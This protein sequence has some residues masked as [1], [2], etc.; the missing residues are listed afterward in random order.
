MIPPSGRFPTSLARLLLAGIVL[1]GLVAGLRYF[2]T[3]EPKAAKSAITPS[4]AA[5]EPGPAFASSQRLIYRQFGLTEDTVYMA[6]LVSIQ[7]PKM[8]ARIPHARG[9]G[10]AASISPDGQLLAYTVLPTAAHDPLTQAELWALDT[11]SGETTLLAQGL[12]LLPAPIWSSDS[13]S[14]LVRRHE[15]REGRHRVELLMVDAGRQESN[16]VLAKDDVLDLFPVGLS[17]DSASLYYAEIGRDG[18][19]F[20]RLSRASGSAAPLL[21]ASPSVA[22]DWQLSPDGSRIVFVAPERSEGRISMRAYLVDLTEATP[23]AK[24]IAVFPG[25]DHFSPVW[26]TNGRSITIGTSAVEITAGATAIVPVADGSLRLAP[27]PS[28]GFDLPIAWSPNDQFLA[29]RSFQGPSPQ[30]AGEG[31]TVV[32]AADGSRWPLGQGQDAEFIGWVNQGAR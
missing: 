16:V 11:A 29:A 28:K 2:F 7:S 13:S 23:Q 19:H 17:P 25:Q 22:R 31:R 9:W 3:S 1:L 21:H 18:T 30:N 6:E 15:V 10:I 26:S 14:V 4:V 5:T 24:P 12:D 20:G 8:L 27:P 32:I